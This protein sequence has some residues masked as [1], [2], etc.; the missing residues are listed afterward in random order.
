MTFWRVL[1]QGAEGSPY[2]GGTWLL[3]ARFPPEFPVLPPEMRFVTPILHCNVNCYGKICHSILDRNWTSDTTMKDV[4]N[5][6]YGLLLT[7]DTDDPL[8]TAQ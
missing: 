4:F 6:I 7:P 1:L 8:D 2:E 5:C 3:F